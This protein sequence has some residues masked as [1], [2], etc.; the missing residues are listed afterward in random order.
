MRPG[1][2]IVAGNTWARIRCLRNEAGV[3]IEE[4]GPG[5][6][7]EID[8]W[9]EQPIAGDEVLQAPSEQKAKS[10][11]DYRNE[12]DEREKLAEDMEAINDTRKF[13][14]EKREA[15]KQ[16][17]LLAEAS[18]LGG[19]ELIPATK[20]EAP[21]GAKQVYFIIKGDVSGSVEAVVDSISAI[22]TREVQAH[23]LR[24]GVGQISEFDI[25]HAAAANGYVINFNTAID[26]KISSLAEASKVQIIDQNIIYR[27][28]DEVKAKMSEFLPALVTHKVLGE[29]EVAQVFQ[30]N[31]KGRQTKAMAGCKVRNGIVSKNAKVR[32]LRGGEKIFDGRLSL[33]AYPKYHCNVS[34]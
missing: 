2:F 17:K 16:E 14:Q 10:V 20:D 25:E 34:Y 1:D 23:I 13:E 24:S 32:V 6:P 3:D 27:L 29:A 31:I 33:L 12:R 18:K 30:I 19:E 28:M 9:K 22:S 15:E 21:K 26:P 8:G 11:V 5:T 7:V 4:A